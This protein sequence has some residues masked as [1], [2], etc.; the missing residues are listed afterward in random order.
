M[1]GLRVEPPR[2]LA[3]LPEVAVGPLP[4]LPAPL[5]AAPAR[6]LEADEPR[7]AL[8]RLES[9]YAELQASRHHTSH[10][11]ARKARAATSDEAPEPE[12]ARA[13]QAAPAAAPQDAVAQRPERFL[14]TYSTDA[15]GVRSYKANE[16]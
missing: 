7:G 9:L 10:R 15:N 8:A 1:A 12:P 16:P 13:P 14:G 2:A 6:K 11:A 5:P 3:P 4:P